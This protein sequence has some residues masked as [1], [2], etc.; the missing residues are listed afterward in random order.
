MAMLLDIDY[1]H[2]GYGAKQPRPMKP[3]ARYATDRDV[4]VVANSRLSKLVLRYE[5]SGFGW[6]H[7]T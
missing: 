1:E 6:I 3:T 5:R 4:V 7:F 2:A